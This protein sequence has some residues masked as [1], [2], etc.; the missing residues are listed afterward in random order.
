MSEISP[1]PS[2][3]GGPGF[4]FRIGSHRQDL[5]SVWQS[6]GLDS[7]WSELKSVMLAWPPDSLNFE[8]EA[9][10]QL[11]LEKPDLELM[12]L[13]AEMIAET[14][15]TRGIDVFWARPQQTPP[16]NFVFMRDLVFMTPEGAIIARPASP[17]RAAEA[18]HA[19][20]CLA[21][22]GIPIVATIYGDGLM[23]GADCLWLRTNLVL[24]GIG[25]R[26]NPAGL[27][28]LVAVL[29]RL[30]VATRTVPVPRGAQHL[31]GVATLLD[32]DLAIVDSERCSRA[33]RAVF[34]ALN[35]DIIELDPS[36][37]LRTH[38]GMNLVTLAPRVV[39][40]PAECAEIRA[41]LE[42]HDVEVLEA[43]VTE[44]VKAGGALGCLVA[45]M[46]RTSCSISAIDAHPDAKDEGLDSD[47]DSDDE[48]EFEYE[49][50]SVSVES[51]DGLDVETEIDGDPIIEG[52][53]RFD[54]IEDQSWSPPPLLQLNTESTEESDSTEV[55]V[56]WEDTG[57]EGASELEAD[58][59]TVLDPGTGTGTGTDVNA[60][61]ELEP[62]LEEIGDP[63]GGS[64][65]DKD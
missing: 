51:Q 15:E 38:R 21:A 27:A 48:I 25:N 35:I 34:S 20:E 31:L 53:V 42:A 7:E 47:S 52:A 41:V 54:D 40:M 1:T 26:T 12:R 3:F 60:S 30:G 19:A 50:S 16:P 43:E 14:F 58:T 61:P 64:D 10:D 37:E 17:I 62:D 11:M 33:L 4:E 55:F 39:L 5:G 24:I 46:E 9:D 29:S 2:T 56:E 65:L 57:I 28:Q 59:E 49:D 63:D 23:E 45:P 18:R 44:Y 32:R 8:G 36:E 22:A 6:C 13:Q